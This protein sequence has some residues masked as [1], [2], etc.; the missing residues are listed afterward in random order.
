MIALNG[1]NCNEKLEKLEGN[2]SPTHKENF[3][4]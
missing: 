2:F 1:K 3:A 4:I